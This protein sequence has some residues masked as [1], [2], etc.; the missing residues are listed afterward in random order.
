MKTTQ[1]AYDAALQ[2]VKGNVAGVAS[3]K[4]NLDIAAKNLSRTTVVSPIDGVVSLLSVKKG[5]RVVGNS[6]MA[7]TEMMRVAD[8]S[9]IETIVD[10]GE[11]DI[12][13]VHLG[14]SALIEV[15][16]YNN[17]KF[18]GIVT[19]IA[20][21]VTT[22]GGSSTTVSMNDVT[23]YKVHIRL[24]P[25]SYMDLINPAKPRNFPFRPGMTANA[26]IQTKTQSGVL[27]APINSVTTREK[28]SDNPAHG[29]DD[30]KNEDAK[31]DGGEN[32]PVKNIVSADDLNE[33]V[34]VLQ[35]DGKV[36]KVKVKTSIQDINYI[37]IVDGVKEGD[38]VVSGPYNIISRTLK[39]GMKVKVVPKEK[40]FEVKKD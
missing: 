23:N 21:S 5:E 39:D 28:N 30:T 3:A 11:N 19:Q 26:D 27:S 22:A 32:D 25:N 2:T 9:K 6:M 10:V 29:S 36:K 8:L 16:A 15:D 34:F 37:E 14:D 38:Q 40:L 1:A 33:V 35:P 7:G 13:K 20:S 24:S 4:A 31:K 12:P 18:R 17:R